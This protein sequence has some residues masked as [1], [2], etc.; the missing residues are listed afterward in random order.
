MPPTRT[1]RKVLRSGKMYASD[2]AS[3]AG[4][5]LSAK[6]VARIVGVTPKT[7]REWCA[8]G[9]LDAY[10]VGALGRWRVRREAVERLRTE[11]GMR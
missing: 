8:S 7:V 10:R 9:Q 2:S 1:R 4:P 5:D 6:E 11:R 3:A